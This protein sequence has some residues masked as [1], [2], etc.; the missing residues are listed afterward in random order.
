V[1]HKFGLS[2]YQKDKRQKGMTTWYVNKHQT[3]EQRREKYLMLKR[4]GFSVAW[5][6]RARDWT[7]PHVD[8]VIKGM[9]ENDL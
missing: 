8:Q 1:D 7:L 9:K 6:R 4:A 2:N 3:P 5:A